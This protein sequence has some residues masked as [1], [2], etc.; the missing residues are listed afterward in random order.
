MML[1][2][3]S[4]RQEAN[5]GMLVPSSG[6]LFEHTDVQCD[7]CQ[8]LPLR[9]VRFM[10]LQCANYDLCESCYRT[11]EHTP[12]HD[13]K[14]LKQATGRERL[15]TSTSGREEAF[16]FMLNFTSGRQQQPALLNPSS[17]PLVPQ[18]PSMLNFTSGRQQPA[19]LLNPPSVAVVPQPFSGRVPEA[20]GLS[21][22]MLPASEPG[23]VVHRG[24]T[25]DSCQMH[26]LLG[27]RYKC[28]DC[29]DYDLCEGC[30][31]EYEDMSHLVP[32]GLAA[33]CIVFHGDKAQH[34]R[35]HKFIRMKYPQ[36]L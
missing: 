3:T 34:A 23:A 18:A 1:N 14:P 21:V 28:A 24:V 27:V 30:L 15:V 11:T 9:G 29:A 10:C 13:F 17:V 19:P 20:N 32:S 8:M 26:P 7:G 31:S 33:S 5:F 22:F 25:C 2:S 12:G 6:R 16:T 36:A 4:G 35:N